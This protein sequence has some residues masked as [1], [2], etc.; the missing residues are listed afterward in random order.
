[1]VYCCKLLWCFGQC[2]F[3]VAV[4]ATTFVKLGVFVVFRRENVEER[5]SNLVGL[6]EGGSNPSV[7]SGMN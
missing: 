3:V 4:Q 6:F 2:P 7:S 1:M 5:D